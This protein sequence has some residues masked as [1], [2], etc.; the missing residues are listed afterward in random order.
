MKKYR[1]SRYNIE[2]EEL[3]ITKESEHSI[4]INNHCERKNTEEN[5]HFNTWYE[6]YVYLLHREHEKVKHF[7]YQLKKSTRLLESVQDM[8]CPTNA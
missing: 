5:K 2:V 7:Q 1:V 8:R 4:W 6:A 3:E